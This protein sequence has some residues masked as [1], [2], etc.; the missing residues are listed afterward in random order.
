LRDTVQAELERVALR[1]GEGVPTIL[2]R[3]SF[4]T[5][6]RRRSSG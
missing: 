4:E 1:E 3:P 5:R 6:R 2:S